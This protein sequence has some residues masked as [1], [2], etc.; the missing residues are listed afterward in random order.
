MASASAVSSALRMCTSTRRGLARSFRP[1]HQ[2]AS[3]RAAGAVAILLIGVGKGC[4][5]TAP[6][7]SVTLAVRFFKRMRAVDLIRKKRDSGN[8]PRRNQLPRFRLH[9]R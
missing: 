6:E 5:L 4:A 1:D 7:A 3:R 8:S 9:A 2:S